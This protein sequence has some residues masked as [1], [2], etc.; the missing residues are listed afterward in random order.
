MSGFNS[1][2]ISRI[3]ALSRISARIKFGFASSPSPTKDS[4]S[5]K[6]AFS[7]L[8]SKNKLSGLNLFTCLAISDPI[9]PPAPVI[10]IFF[11]NYIT[12]LI[13]I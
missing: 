10:K 13:I 6:S 12:I 5:D 11:F 9:E 2:S 3:L 7:S 4:W 8:S 1:S